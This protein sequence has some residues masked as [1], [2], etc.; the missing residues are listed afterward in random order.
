MI[1]TR[2]DWCISRQRIWGVPIAVFM[3]EGCNHPVIDAALNRKIVGLFEREGAEAWHTSATDGLLAEGTTC[4]HCGG[5]A[6]RKEFD[7]LD[8]WF[9]SGTSWFA[10]C[11][12]DADLKDAYTAFPERQGDGVP[13]S[14]GRR[15]ASGLVPLVAADHRSALRGRAPYSHVAHG[16]IHAGRAGPRD[17]EV[18]GQWRG[19]GGYCQ[20]AGRG[21][22]PA[23]G[24][25]ASIS[26]KTWRPART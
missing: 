2:P 4:A 16:G 3:C 5:K 10:V 26:A 21:D 11:E 8:V 23:V 25:V 22:R 15:P 13:V 6:F 24:R 17:V 14:G 19:P 12:A 7:I 1:A 18:T 20:H 9:D